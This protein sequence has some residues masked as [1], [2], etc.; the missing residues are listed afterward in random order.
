MEQGLGQSVLISTFRYA[1]KLYTFQSEVTVI[2]FLWILDPS[3]IQ[4]CTKFPSLITN[5]LLM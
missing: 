5:V 1:Y 3:A 4:D 2:I